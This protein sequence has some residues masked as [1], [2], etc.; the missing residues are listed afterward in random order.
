M[1]EPETG[2]MLDDLRVDAIVAFLN[3]LTGG[4]YEHLVQDELAPVRP[5]ALRV[6]PGARGRP[7]AAQSGCQG[8]PKRPE[9]PWI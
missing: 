4:R 5:A 1:V 6:Y 8:A 2:P 9:T 3:T 7:A